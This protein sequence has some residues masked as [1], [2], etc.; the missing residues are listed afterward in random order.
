MGEPAQ[1]VG[2]QESW[3][4]PSQATALGRVG[5][6]TLTGQEELVLEVWVRV[7]QIELNLSPAYGEFGWCSL[8]SAE[9]FVLIV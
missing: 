3:P 6:H 4:S 9:E 1:G 2:E 5:F 8:R 7:S